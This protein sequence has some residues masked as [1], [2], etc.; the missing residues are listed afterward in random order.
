MLTC[1]I[2]GKQFQ[3]F[4]QFWKHVKSRHG[5]V[6]DQEVD[7]VTTRLLNEGL[8]KRKA[9]DLEIRGYVRKPKGKHAA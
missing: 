7:T 4:T 8:K 2:D 9:H 1:P 5:D 6:L 3:S